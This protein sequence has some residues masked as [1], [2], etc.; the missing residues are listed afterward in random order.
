MTP[1]QMAARIA[2]LAGVTAAATTQ[3]VLQ[4]KGGQPLEVGAKVKWFAGGTSRSGVVTAVRANDE[5]VVTEDTSGRT[6]SLP[7]RRIAR[8]SEQSES[9]TSGGG[10]QPEPDTVPDPPGQLA[11]STASGVTVGD[12]LVWDGE[13]YEVVGIP[14]RT[15]NSRTLLQRNVNT[16]VLG[17]TVLAAA[18]PVWLLA[19]ST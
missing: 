11:A 2:D 5:V 3:L 16:D 6:V 17:L 4:D 10:S 7:V 13:P 9:P 18:T 12:V 19:P 8:I 14:A 1:E 15:T